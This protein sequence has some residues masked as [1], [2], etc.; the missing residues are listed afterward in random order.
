MV[1]L[2]NTKRRLH[3][4]KKRKCKFRYTKIEQNEK[5]RNKDEFGVVFGHSRRFSERVEFIHEHQSN[6]SI[7]DITDNANI[8]RRNVGYS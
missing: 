6:H 2:L 1:P 5:R 8:V 4:I 7:G 3:R